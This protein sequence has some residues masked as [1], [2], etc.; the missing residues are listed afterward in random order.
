MGLDMKH[1]IYMHGGTCAQ[2]AKP[3]M[4]V[5]YGGTVTR[6]SLMINFF[7]DKLMDGCTSVQSEIDHG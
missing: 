4:L 3:D 6:E 7:F 5:V 2:I 1:R